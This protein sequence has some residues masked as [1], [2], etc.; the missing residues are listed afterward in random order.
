MMGLRSMLRSNHK[1]AG[2][3]DVGSA[4]CDEPGGGG[5]RCRCLCSVAAD[6]ATVEPSP[7]IF[8]P[9]DCLAQKESLFTL[10]P[11]EQP[12]LAQFSLFHSK[13]IFLAGAIARDRVS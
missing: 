7:A 9:L 5:L 12:Y 3:M 1:L 8:L 4:R 13:L 2:M 6:A 10:L 11:Q